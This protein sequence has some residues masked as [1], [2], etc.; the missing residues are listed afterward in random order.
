MNG[1]FVPSGFGTGE[2]ED[3]RSR[4]IG[5]IE[6]VETEEEARKFIDEIK[7]KHYDARH[8]CWC[9]IINNGQ[10]RYSDD[11]E[12]QGTAGQPML[13]V[14]EKKNISNVVCVVTRYFGGVLLG[15]GGLL[16]A[17]TKAAA[18]ALEDAGI[19]EIRKLSVYN[20]VISYSQF[21]T[22][23]RIAE[24]QGAV[25]KNVEYGADVTLEVL[26]PEDGEKELE[27]AITN[28]TSG[29]CIC[30]KNGEVFEAVK[31]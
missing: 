4:F 22:V 11:G 2:Y 29:K 8:N 23:K 31:I 21:E 1:I 12:P 19:S 15:T 9:Y 20:I 7:S 16:R 3:R 13:A 26:V 6:K 14:F 18:V 28:I 5:Y 10:M 17:Y 30:I 24:K 25:V 27:T